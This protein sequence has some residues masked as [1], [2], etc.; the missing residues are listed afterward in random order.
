MKKNTLDIRSYPILIKSI[1]LV[2]FARFLTFFLAM[3]SDFILPYR[4]SFPYAGLLENYS[5]PHWI[6]AF[7]GFD[8]VH[9]L[10]I[11]ENGYSFAG[12]VEAFFP[13]WPVS[14]HLAFKMGNT[15]GYGL[16]ANFFLM[17][18][19]VYFL[20]HF[21][22]SCYPKINVNR[23]L[24]LFLVFPTSMFFFAM[25]SE[26]LFMLLIITTF[27]AAHHKKWWL[28]A[29]LT[30]IASATR[31]VG[32]ILVPA[33]LIELWMQSNQNTALLKIRFTHVQ[34]FVTSK[35]KEIV[36]IC[37]GCLGLLAYMLYLQINFG[38]AL[39]F[40]TVQSQW[41]HDRSDTIILYPQV[42]YRY[43]KIM[44]T[45]FEFTLGWWTVAQ[46]MVV[47]LIAPFLPLLF[48]R[49]I[50]LSHLFFGFC[51]TIIPTLTGTFSS[52]PRYILVAFPIFLGL[53]YL[54]EKR[55]KLFWLWILFSTLALICNTILFVQG[56][57]VA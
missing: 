39:L 43:I 49:K 1:V 22:K 54:L 44:L 25:Y 16:L 55:P 38:D 48:F 53:Y 24:L 46:E 30:I 10:T 7:A 29:L 23:F 18:P 42:I 34:K 52:L 28:A 12:L 3:V 31:I 45:S 51:V 9:Y 13:V 47:G 41:G 19:L 26:T 4:P 36:L 8:G 37:T 35:W 40:K 14:L 11:A 20:I 33:L 2:T 27:L 6:T 32:V 57:W 5:L 21:I 50:R 17:I 56:Y 15:L